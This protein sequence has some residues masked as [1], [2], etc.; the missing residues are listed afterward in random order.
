MGGGHEEVM[1]YEA[2]A[3]MLHAHTSVHANGSIIFMLYPEFTFGTCPE[4]LIV[5][6]DVE[7]G[8]SYLR[9]DCLR[10]SG[11]D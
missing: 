6:G 1:E 4:E 3:E 2:F 11:G 7:S 8:D 10:N 5:K 9:M